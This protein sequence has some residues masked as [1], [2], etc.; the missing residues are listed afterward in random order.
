MNER[1][2]VLVGEAI[3]AIR[4]GADAALASK[5]DREDFDS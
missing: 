5:K 2:D 1:A 3:A 4:R